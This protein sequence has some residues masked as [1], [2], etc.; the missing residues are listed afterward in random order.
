MGSYEKNWS[1][2]RHD[3]KHFIEQKSGA[4]RCDHC[5][6]LVVINEF[7]GTLN[8]NHC[9][10]CLWSKHVDIKKGDRQSA[11]K[12]GMEPIGLTFKHEGLSRIGELML[13]HY[14]HGCGKLSI[15]RIA[16]DDMV[17]EVYGVYY[18]SQELPETF[19]HQIRENGIYFATYTNKDEIDYQLIG[20]V[21]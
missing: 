3:T 15:N 18:Q 20:K 5:R 2:K 7:M 14:C 1:R 13:I 11:C 19:I 4:F 12:A 9:N 16:A 6:A 21:K 8:R 17:E 10:F